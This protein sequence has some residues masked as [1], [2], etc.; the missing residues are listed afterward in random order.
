MQS[1]EMLRRKSYSDNFYNSKYCI[2]SSSNN[3][4][5]LI[6]IPEEE[7][8]KNGEAILKKIMDQSF[9]RIAEIF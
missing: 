6:K 9:S 2:S 4:Y 8:R 1:K 5:Y 7:T 3:Q